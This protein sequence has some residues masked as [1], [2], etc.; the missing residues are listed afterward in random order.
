MLPIN[1]IAFRTNS[2][3]VTAAVRA[4]RTAFVREHPDAVFY[5]GYPNYVKDVAASVSS[6]LIEQ[7][8]AD[9]EGGAGGELRDR[10]GGDKV[11]P[12]KMK[13]LRSSSALALNLFG[14]IKP[15]IGSLTLADCSSFDDLAFERP[16]DARLGRLPPHL[17]VLLTGTQG[18]AAIEVKCL[19]H[20]VPAK[21]AFAPAYGEI[22]ASDKRRNSPWFRHMNEFAKTGRRYRRLHA[23]QLIKHY[24]GL[25]ANA[26]RPITLVYLFWEPTNAD[27]ISVRNRDGQVVNPYVE[28]REDI[29]RFANAVTDDTATEVRF[30]AVPLLGLLHDWTACTAHPE[31][32]GHAARLRRRYE[33][34]IGA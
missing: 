14:P 29:D 19:E 6:G 2:D 1:M 3:H 16:F 33:V 24:F 27:F 34:A 13:A 23:A 12:A 11:V 4:L 22:P 31:L 20:L 9:F 5:P 28:H 30:A 10:G 32:A 8:G 25:A 18:D 21:N 26:R 15:L 7:F 17:D